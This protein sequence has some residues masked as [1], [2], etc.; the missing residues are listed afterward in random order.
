MSSYQRLQIGALQRARNPFRGQVIADGGGGNSGDITGGTDNA[1]NDGMV[2]I[3]GG[4]SG[5]D[6]GDLR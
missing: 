6:G 3:V 4:G 5:V 1:N 2:K